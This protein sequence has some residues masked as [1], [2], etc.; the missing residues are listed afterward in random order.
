MDYMTTTKIAQ[1]RLQN[2]I[3]EAAAYRRARQ[4]GNVKKANLLRQLRTFL[5]KT[6]TLTVR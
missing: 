6:F 2:M 5:V 4:Y 3:D 1:E